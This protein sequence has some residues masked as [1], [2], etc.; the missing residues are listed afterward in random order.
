[1]VRSVVRLIAH[2]VTLIAERA[3]DSI[4]SVLEPYRSVLQ[5]N[6]EK[7]WR[8][9][10]MHLA[11]AKVNVLQYLLDLAKPVAVQRSHE[12]ASQQ[13][14]TVFTGLKRRLAFSTISWCP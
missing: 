7:A 11:V 8:G 10:H 12:G 9:I 14:Q 3:P 1:M 4:R 2:A 13:Q 6:P 5:R